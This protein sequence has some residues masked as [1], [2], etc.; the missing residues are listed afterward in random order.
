[1]RELAFIF[2]KA[3]TTQILAEQILASS[4]VK[5]S[6]KS[7]KEAGECQSRSLSW[8]EVVYSDRTVS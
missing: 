5:R 4:L 2:H 3:P 8:E 7:A 1:V 6:R